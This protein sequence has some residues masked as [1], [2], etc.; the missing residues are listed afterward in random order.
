[1]TNRDG[2]E[3]GPARG[4]HVEKNGEEWTLVLTRQL[5]HAPPLVWKALTDPV[6]LA[7]WAPFDAAGSLGVVGQVM[8][9]AVGSPQ[10]QVSEATVSR[11]DEPRLLEYNWGGG[12]LRWELE[13]VGAGTRLTLWHNINRQYIAWG[14]AGWHICFDVLDR[15]LGGAPIGRIVGADAM[16]FQGWQRLTSEYASQFNR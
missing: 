9:T 15:L 14:A 1:M 12:N 8:L 13:A 5:R 7:Q 4:A 2:Y 6:H 3:P 10:A 11:A 16:A